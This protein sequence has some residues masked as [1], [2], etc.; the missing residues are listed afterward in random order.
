MSSAAPKY[1]CMPA[2]LRTC[3]VGNFSSCAK[4]HLRLSRRTGV[5]KFLYTQSHAETSLLLYCFIRD[6]GSGRL[7]V[8]DGPEAPVTSLIHQ[9]CVDPHCQR[10]HAAVS[11]PIASPAHRNLRPFGLSQRMLTQVLDAPSLTQRFAKRPEHGIPFS[12]LA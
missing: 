5:D 12:L 2:T 4:I 11:R 6:P 8:S 3:V 9:H 1:L 7:A 10:P